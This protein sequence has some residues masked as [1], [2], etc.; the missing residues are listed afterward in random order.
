ML[1]V[2]VREL[3]EHLLERP[4]EVV[5]VGSLRRDAGGPERLLKSLGEAWVRGVE[6]DWGGVFAG[7][8]AERVELPTY[9]FQRERFWLDAHA[10]TG[11][12]RGAGLHSSSHPLLGATVGLATGEGVLFTG[13]LS[14]RSHP[15]LAD[16]AVAGSVLLPG[17]AFVELALHAGAQV[18]CPT[19]R[20]LTLERPLRFTGEGEVAMQIVVGEYDGGTRQ[21]DVYARAEGAALGDVGASTEGWTRHASGTLASDGGT[22]DRHP[23]Q[24]R[25]A[26]LGATWPPRDAAPLPVEGLYDELAELGYE[27]GPVFQGLQA[28]WRVGEEVFAEVALPAD[29]EREGALFGLHPA[30]LDAALHAIGVAR[31][32]GGG[33]EGERRLAFLWEGLE[34]YGGGSSRLRLCLALRDDGAVSLAAVDERGEPIVSVEELRLRAPADALDA[35]AGRESLYCVDWGPCPS[36]PQVAAER[37]AVV[38]PGAEAPGAAGRLAATLGVAGVGAGEYP[39]LEH[40]AA[41]IDAGAAVPDVVIVDLPVGCEVEPSD[42]VGG[43]GG[44]GAPDGPDA[45]AVTEAA[46][47]ALGVV[48]AWLAD[49]RFAGSRLALVTRGAL[50]ARAGE[51]VPGLA[52]APVWGL[53]RCAQVEHPD[54]FVLV[55]LD[56]DGDSAR[57]LPAALAS[58]AAQ[59]AVRAGAA[60]VPRLAHTKADAQ[61]FALDPQGTVLIT[62]GTG[63]LGGRV[64]RR[65]VERHGARHLLLVSRRG[66]EVPGAGEL[67]RELRELGA[68][69]TIAACDVADRA[70]LAALVGSPAPEHPLRMV[71]HAAVALDDGVIETLTAPALDRALAAKACGALWLH[72]LTAGVG[73]QAFVLFSSMAGLFGG[74]GQGAYA[75]ANAFLDALA[76]RRR[77]LGLPATSLAWG[78]W[79]QAAGVGAALSEANL[80]RIAR[81]GVGGLSGEQGLRAVRPGARR[82]SSAAGADPARVRRVARTRRCRRATRAAGRS[83]A[84]A[85][86]PRRQRAGAPGAASEGDPGGGAPPRDARCGVPR[87]GERAR[88]RLPR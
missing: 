57:A 1:T 46:R 59:L 29:R 17:S 85:G 78:L 16:H 75:A 10:G 2:G 18:G 33:A 28:A 19:V 12:V 42:E 67:A 40:L 9:A 62:G 39:D 87:N 36:G 82:R 65:L 11:D 38:S 27:Y 83:G 64:A 43:A 30:L 61:A 74:T 49:E 31:L 37:L 15:W 23:L 70:Q 55:D 4:D 71:V 53:V 7:S 25:L 73:L 48:Q 22:P 20:E 45:R 66:A 72:E 84:R 35:P 51:G 44:G 80:A 32:A 8:G 13:R 81:A 14:L 5:A 24:R 86:A 88:S 54:R 58:G 69:V 41:A 6:V 47:G 21:I 26:A 76:Q 50:A 52:Q 63:D 34:L 60:L 56:S 3:A 79:E 77:G 68:Q